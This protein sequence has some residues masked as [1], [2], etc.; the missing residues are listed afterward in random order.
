MSLYKNTDSSALVKSGFGKLKGLFCSNSTSLIVEFMDGIT[1]NDDVLDKATATLTSSGAMVPAAHANSE[2]VSTGACAPADYAT[3]VLTSSGVNVTDG[4]TVVIGAITYRFKDTMTQAYDVKIGA[5]AAASLDNLK[6]AINGTGT[7]GVEWFAGTVAHSLVIAGTNADTTQEIWSRTIGTGNNA[8]G[9]TVSAVTLSW[10]DTTLGGG[11]GASNPGVTAAA[12][13]ITLNTTV[14][15]AVVRLAESIGLAAVPYQVLW[16]TSEAVFLDN[17]KVAVNA[18]TGDETKYATG[19]VAHPTLVASTNTNTVQTFF[20]RVI[21]T[22]PNTYPTSTTLANYAFPAATL[23]DGTGN[24]N[25]GVASTAATITINGRVYTVVNELSETSGAAAVVDQVLYG[26]SEAVMLDNFKLAINA[27]A[28]A[29][30]NYSTGTVVNADVTAETNTNTTQVIQAITGGI[31]GNTITVSETLANHT[32]GAGVTTLS[33]G[34]EVNTVMVEQFTLSANT[35][36]PFT[37]GEGIDFNVGLY[38]RVVSGTG[39]VTIEY[40]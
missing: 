12:A 23:E 9:T 24:S 8:L 1:D 40:E 6:A 15:T 37:T 25:P 17:L 19:T 21:G 13:T 11:T 31:V 22:T 27:G 29:G 30:T 10:A 4:D 32:W 14:Y 26:G 34:L 3:S 20:A 33:G 5:S 7:A 38:F 18:A 36:Y 28:T 39:E 16:E 35:F 2:I